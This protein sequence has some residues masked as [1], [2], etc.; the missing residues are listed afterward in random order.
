VS[1]GPVS[2]GLAA[3]GGGE[4]SPLATG[5]LAPRPQL[6]EFDRNIRFGKAPV[7]AG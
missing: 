1:F 2:F 6:D 7:A 3:S 5:P 4:G